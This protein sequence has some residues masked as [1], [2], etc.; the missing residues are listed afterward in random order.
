V[1]SHPGG[2]WLGVRALG[3]A[4]RAAD[5]RGP[6]TSLRESIAAHFDEEDVETVLH[7]VYTGSMERRR[8]FELAK[9]LLDAAA[10]GDL[11]SRGAADTL[12]DEV[13]AFVR[14]AVL[15]LHLEE[16]AVEVVLGGGIFHTRD[17][18]FH[19]RV[20][21]GILAVAPGA[22]VRYLGAPPVLGA[23][24]IGLDFAG[25]PPTA[26]ETARGALRDSVESR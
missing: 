20:G 14:G 15:R 1:I 17:I 22:Q 2:A 24:L 16:T 8:L 10:D 11:E 26:L 19:D 5:G 3:L 6:P 12:A 4:L 13:V 18:A 23:A 9:V 25:A 21:A 7:R